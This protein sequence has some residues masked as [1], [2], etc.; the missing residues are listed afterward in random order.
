[1]NQSK[2][3]LQTTILWVYSIVFMVAISCK[4][5]AAVVNGINQESFQ[6][7]IEEMKR[8]LPSDQVPKL[9][10]A[11]KIIYIYD[12]QQDIDSL[13]W[14]RTRQLLNM[15]TADQIFSM[16]ERTAKEEGIDWDR[17]SLGMLDF[18]KLKKAK[19]LSQEGENEDWQKAVSIKV[20]TKVIDQNRDGVRDALM[21][22]IDLLN[23]EGKPISYSNANMNATLTVFY[24]KKKVYVKNQKVSNSD[25]GKP[26]LLRGIILPF[27]AFDSE[28]I[29]GDEVD[30]DV[31][32]FSDANTF[33]EEISPIEIPYKE[34]IEKTRVNKEEL[35]K[36]KMAATQV[37][38]EFLTSISEG[39]FRKAYKLSVN[40]EWRDYEVFSSKDLGFGMIDKI[41][42]ESVQLQD[43]N[44]EKEKASVIA[45][46]TITIKDGD[47]LEQQKKY[48]VQKV[49]NDWKI[50]SVVTVA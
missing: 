39:D 17:N 20:S 10:E 13:K 28:I 4:K 29:K 7:S 11:V 44:F 46:Y 18:S 30:L 3:K 24:D 49:G 45:K 6:Q 16:A 35:E 19:T 22:F 47:S 2:R 14:S 42:I 12:S 33:S 48:E 43:F 23:S 38:E 15:K 9:D 32:L 37:V 34:Y 8:Q 40:P 5:E 1:M 36:E 50:V 25:V 27:H 41:Q 31:Q 21:I 26:A